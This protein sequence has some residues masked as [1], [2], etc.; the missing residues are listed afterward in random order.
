MYFSER[1]KVAEIESDCFPVMSLLSAFDAQA[2]KWL[3]RGWE[4]K[5]AVDRRRERE[6]RIGELKSLDRIWG[7]DA[8]R[9]ERERAKLFEAW[10][11]IP[12]EQRARRWSGWW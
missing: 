3:T 11:R 1:L 5:E 8:E 2:W 6:A 9:R 10:G 7:N 12:G 4:L